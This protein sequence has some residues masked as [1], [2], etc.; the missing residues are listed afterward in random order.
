[1][2]VTPSDR[3]QWNSFSWIWQSMS[4]Y[5]WKEYLSQWFFS[6][7]EKSSKNES[8]CILCTCSI[9][10]VCKT[11]SYNWN[12]LTL[13]GLTVGEAEEA[14]VIGVVAVAGV[15]VGSGVTGS[16]L[17]SGSW[18]HVPEKEISSTAVC[19]AW[20]SPFPTY[21]KTIWKYSQFYFFCVKPSNYVND[22]YTVKKISDLA[23]NWGRKG[24][25]CSVPEEALCHSLVPKYIV[26]ISIT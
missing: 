25:F 20:A 8:T 6:K 5:Y 26:I 13:Q 19:D 4:I 21:W 16:S 17:F 1:M 2:H 22:T 9:V 23:L 18:A 12:F 7:N 10:S 11:E 24:D 3:Q 14:S 15:I